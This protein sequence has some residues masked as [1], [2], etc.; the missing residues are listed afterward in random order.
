MVCPLTL[1]AFS[2]SLKFVKGAPN[3]DPV[4]IAPS[5]SG[6]VGIT[7]SLIHPLQNPGAPGSPYPGGA[8]VINMTLGF[9]AGAFTINN[10]SFVSPSVPVLLQILSGTQPAQNLLPEGSVF[11]LQKNEVY[12]ININGGTAPGGPHPFHLHG[13]RC[14]KSLPISAHSNGFGLFSTISTSSKASTVRN[15][16]LKTLSVILYFVS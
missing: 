9:N 10:Y 8:H 3:A 2:G 12:E 7:E 13:V 1:Q 14:P 15:I 16:T 5:S 4:T 11:G 6:V